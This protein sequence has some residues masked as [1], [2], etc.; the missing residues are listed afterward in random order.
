MSKRRS[1]NG[2]KFTGR[3]QRCWIDGA[4]TINHSSSHTIHRGCCRHW[5]RGI[6]G[7]SSACRPGWPAIFVAPTVLV[8]ES[9]RSRVAVDSDDEYSSGDRVCVDSWTWRESVACR[10]SA[11]GKLRTPLP[12]HYLTLKPEGGGGRVGKVICKAR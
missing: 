2:E 9:A 7:G 8:R 3:V 6:H 1:F 4:G 5:W 12:G 11:Q 10:Q